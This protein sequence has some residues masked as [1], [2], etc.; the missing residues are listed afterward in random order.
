MGRRR[1]LLTIKEPVRGCLPADSA[2]HRSANA[3]TSKQ[4]TIY[5]ESERANPSPTCTCT[6]S[7][8]PRLARRLRARFMHARVWRVESKYQPDLPDLTARAP[9]CRLLR[10]QSLL[11]QVG[12]DGAA[13]LLLA[14]PAVYM[15][16]TQPV[17]SARVKLSLVLTHS[18]THSRAP[19]GRPEGP[20]YGSLEPKFYFRAESRLHTYNTPCTWT[21]TWCTCTCARRAV[22]DVRV[23][24]TGP[25]PA[26]LPARCV[27]EGR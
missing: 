26:N 27:S 19:A 7:T 18:L 1:D 9:V 20:I 23:I 17:S 6:Y 10:K 4:E 3:G 25:K 5:I 2:A 12:R 15:H 16:T 14:S 21:W 22:V 11:R 8:L 13:S 24:S